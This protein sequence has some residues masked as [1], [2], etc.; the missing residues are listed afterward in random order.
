[1][2]KHEPL[3][4]L[5]ELRN[6]SRQ[7]ESMYTLEKISCV[8]DQH[9]DTGE[10]ISF[11]DSYRKIIRTNQWLY[12]DE[13]NAIFNDFICRWRATSL[14]YVSSGITFFQYLISNNGDDFGRMHALAIVSETFRGREG[15][16]SKI[17]LDAFLESYTE[18]LNHLVSK[19]VDA[20]ELEDIVSLFVSTMTENYLSAESELIMD[21]YAFKQVIDTVPDY[22]EF[23]DA[24]QK[25]SGLFSKMLRE[26]SKYS[27]VDFK[28]KFDLLNTTIKAMDSMKSSRTTIMKEKHRLKEQIFADLLRIDAQAAR[29]FLALLE[30]INDLNF[31]NSN[32]E[33]KYSFKGWPGILHNFIFVEGM[34]QSHFQDIHQR[35]AVINFNAEEKTQ[36]NTIVQNTQVV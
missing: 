11:I 29:R 20:D 8:V 15:K 1:M 6:A 2:S 28:Q 4:I 12:S 7:F 17:G 23:K 32:I 33:V 13:G 34:L 9:L 21:M 36:W 30:R 25:T 19:V 3:D 10:H 26:Y 18:E 35:Q 27:L 24:D 22:G 14:F 5:A 16:R 31:M